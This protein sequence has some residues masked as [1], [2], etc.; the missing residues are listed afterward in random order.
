MHCFRF[1]TVKHGNGTLKV[2]IKKFYLRQMK[3]KFSAISGEISGR[4]LFLQDQ[5]EIRERINN[6]H[7][8]GTQIRIKIGK[9]QK[10][11]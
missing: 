3:E 5:F 8:V 6:A 2:K 10:A 7:L 1:E 9:C 11:L 4:Y